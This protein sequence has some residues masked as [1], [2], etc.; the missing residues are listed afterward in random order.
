MR[1][2]EKLFYENNKRKNNRKT[3]EEWEETMTYQTRNRKETINQNSSSTWKSKMNTGINTA[4]SS[5]DRLAVFQ[6]QKN[7]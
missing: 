5:F 4:Q 1:V 7:S 2:T 6:T 3:G